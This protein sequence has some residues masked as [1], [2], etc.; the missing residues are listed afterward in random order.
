MNEP[1]ESIRVALLRGDWKYV[2][3]ML[4]DMKTLCMNRKGAE[5]IANLIARIEEQVVL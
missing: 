2:I 3:Q 1:Q 4:R 5:E